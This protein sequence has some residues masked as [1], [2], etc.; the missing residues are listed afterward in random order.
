MSEKQA[1]D[2]ICS[3]CNETVLYFCKCEIGEHLCQNGHHW[4]FDANGL[5]VEGTSH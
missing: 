5:R 1:S 4:Y 3:I 2:T